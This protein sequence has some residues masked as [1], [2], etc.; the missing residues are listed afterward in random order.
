VVLHGHSGVS[1]ILKRCKYDLILPCPVTVVVKFWVM[2]I[3][4]CNLSVTTGKY[5]VVIAP[6]V[7]L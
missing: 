5:S 6:F 2:F 4:V 1:I 7:V 3:F